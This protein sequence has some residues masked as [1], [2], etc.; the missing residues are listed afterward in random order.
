[1]MIQGMNNEKPAWHESAGFLLGR[2]ANISYGAVR[3]F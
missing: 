2:C 1:M 3:P